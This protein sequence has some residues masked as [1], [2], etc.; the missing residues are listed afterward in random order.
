[1][2]GLKAKV[3]RGEAEAKRAEDMVVVVVRVEG[4]EVRV[5]GAYGLRGLL[6][7]AGLKWQQVS[8]ALD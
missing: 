2:R 7:Q 4:G 5:E 3:A 6:S 1:M 8:G